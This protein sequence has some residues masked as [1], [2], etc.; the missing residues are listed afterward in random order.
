[1][2]KTM[3]TDLE[4]KINVFFSFTTEIGEGGH[5]LPGESNSVENSKNPERL[6]HFKVNRTNWNVFFIGQIA[7]AFGQSNYKI[8]SLALCPG[9]IGGSFRVFVC[10]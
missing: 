10:S 1:M 2:I 7:I 5:L 8:F 6:K 3:E 9:D 4:S